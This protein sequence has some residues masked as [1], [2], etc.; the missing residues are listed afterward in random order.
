LFS[1]T[2][3]DNIA[4]L[5]RASSEEVVA[6]AQL[7][8]CHEMILHLP[9]GYETEIGEGG[10]M[11]SAGQRQRIGLARAVFAAPRLVVLDEPNANLDGEGEIALA[12]TLVRLKAQG[13]AVVVISHRQSLLMQVD[14]ILVM[15]DG[16]IDLLGRRDE[17]MHRLAP[18]TATVPKAA[19]AVPIR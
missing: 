12:R 4:R 16:V 6:A 18:A 14:R 10:I 8:G 19:V 13:A 17:V 1:G 15:R 2:V 7:A 5:G 3:F 11:L 9:K